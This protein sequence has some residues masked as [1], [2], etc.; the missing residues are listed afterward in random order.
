MESVLSMSFQWLL[1]YP[2]HPQS[3]IADEFLPILQDNHVIPL[4]TDR[5]YL[6]KL[7]AFNYSLSVPWLNL[8]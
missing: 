5:F 8:R 3:F 1:F 7:I 2:G 6:G 4:N